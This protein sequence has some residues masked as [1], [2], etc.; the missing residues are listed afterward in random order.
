MFL[1]NVFFGRL[2]F[3]ILTLKMIMDMYLLGEVILAIFCF[4]TKEYYLLYE[5]TISAILDFSK[6]KTLIR[7]VQCTLYILSLSVTSK[8]E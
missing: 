7:S 5:N 6:L 4:Y 8:S 2:E 1:I 3:N